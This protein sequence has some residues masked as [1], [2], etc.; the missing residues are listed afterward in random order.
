MAEVLLFDLGNVVIDIDFGRA[1]AAWGAAAGVPAAALAARFEVDAAYQAHERGEITG[2]QYFAALRESLQLQALSDAQLEAGW[3]AILI[4]EKREVTELIARLPP[5]LPRYVFSNA[6]PAHQLHW[7]RNFAGAV[8]PFQ[9]V[10][11]SSEIGH[12][13]PDVAAFEYVAR[14]IGVP[15][16][17]ILFFDDLLPNVEGARAAGMEAVQVTSAEDVRLALAPYLR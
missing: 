14:E 15:T 10:F 13:K 5:E 4:G 8:A 9:R 16:H 11:V 2:A 17:S 6:N 1:F 7:E 12:R 3:N